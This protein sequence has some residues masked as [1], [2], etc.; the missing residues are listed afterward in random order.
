MHQGVVGVNSK[1]RQCMP[2]AES[3]KKALNGRVMGKREETFENGEGTLQW[4]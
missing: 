2:F 4:N 3:K 1:L